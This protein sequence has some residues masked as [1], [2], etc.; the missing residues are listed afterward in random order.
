MNEY[1][2][3]LSP[4][5]IGSKIAANRLVAH[6]LETNTAL[7]NGAPSPA[8]FDRY[9]RLTSGGWGI[10]CIECTSV[11]EEDRPVRRQLAL[12]EET[13]GDFTALAD[14]MRA[15]HP[16]PLLFAQ[17]SHNGRHVEAETGRRCSPA[18][19]DDPDCRLM[20]RDEILYIRDATI[21]SA[22]LA[23][24]AG[25]D[26]V[27]IKQ[28]HAFFGAEI[29]APRNVR[30]DEYGGDFENRFRFFREVIEGIRASVGELLVMSRIAIYEGGRGEFGTAG[31]DD[32][33]LD[34]AEPRLFLQRLA[35]LGVH[36]V[37]V[38]GPPLPGWPEDH[39]TRPTR[40]EELYRALRLPGLAKRELL[41]TD[42]LTLNT[43]N[44]V[45]GAD[46]PCAASYCLE[47]G[48]T[49]LIGFGRQTLADPLMPR[50]LATGEA[51]H[52][53][54]ANGGCVRRFSSSEP[55]QCDVYPLC[56]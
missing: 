55:V 44:S 50:K 9:R 11:V 37:S 22:E 24:E 54:Q 40:E 3:F 41:G 30:E 56:P 48:L 6:P 4:I 27:D 31:Y 15:A 45:M 34:L 39:K 52:I 21:R 14:T 51:V 19:T 16:E 23:A 17:L 1:T 35:E 18:P 42:T 13:A 12:T 32:A 53:C 28:C 7:E 43:G 33:T 20:S 29:L 46:W 5:A 36:I 26:G 49:D 25:F 2:Q 8:T 38:T 47:S 10:V